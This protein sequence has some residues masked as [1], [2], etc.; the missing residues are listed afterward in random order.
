MSSIRTRFSSAFIALL[1][2]G[3][4]LASAAPA[5]AAHS[6][7]HRAT[8]SVTHS[9]RLHHNPVSVNITSAPSTST[10]LTSA[11]LT[12]KT[13]GPV[14]TTKCSVDNH[15]FAACTSGV[16]LSKLS[17]GRHTFKVEVLSSVDSSPGQPYSVSDQTAW[18]VAAASTTTTTPP[19]TTTTP[20]PTTT[21]PP[22]TS[23][24]SPFFTGTFTGPDKWPMV[25]GSCSHALSDTEIQFTINS[26]CNPGS[27]GHYRTD[28]CSTS[29]CSG[30][31]T[32][33][34]GDV[35][36]AG[37]A[38]CTSVPIDVN[39]ISVVPTNGWMMFA[40]AKDSTAA[41]AGWA[42]MVN[43]YYTGANQFQ[44]SLAHS[45]NDTTW[46][47]IM[48]PGW[49]TLSICTNNAANSSGEVYGI[50]EDGTRLTFNHGTDAGQQSV[51]NYPIIN[52][53]MSSWPLDIDDYTGGAPTNTITTGAPLVSSGTANPPMP[54]NGWNN[55]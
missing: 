51:S 19:P 44:I 21:T 47:G 5:M 32:V 29:G 37:Q 11:W 26:S 52:N 53:G 7:K 14:K 25:Y 49:H 34:S 20:P 43:S 45:T 9:A 40:E 18:T 6:T 30:N 41:N 23:S 46:D 33:A 2:V 54:T 12:W 4:L 42:F 36:Q 10:T 28:L 35:Y 24:S 17:A 1:T 27:D 48:T 55:A 8:R 39:N 50:Y 22:T 38:T 13:S 16:Y 3:A 31:G 15:A